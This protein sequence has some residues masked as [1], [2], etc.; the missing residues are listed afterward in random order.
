MIDAKFSPSVPGPVQVSEGIAT[1]LIGSGI[2]RKHVDQPCR[3]AS[4][5]LKHDST[6]YFP[7]GS[8]SETTQCHHELS[9]L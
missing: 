2:L 9:L 4:D 8:D 6:L 5:L 3:L 7:T 1:G